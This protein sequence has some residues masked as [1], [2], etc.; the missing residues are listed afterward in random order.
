MA[1]RGLVAVSVVIDEDDR[2]L[3]GVWVELHGLPET[4]VGALQEDL[5]EAVEADLSRAK[6]RDLK[7]DDAIIERVSRV[8]RKVCNDQVGKK[9]LV[10]VMTNRLA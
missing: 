5:E 3:D 8:V 1:L 2:P 10:T 4:H 6:A 9:P 7:D